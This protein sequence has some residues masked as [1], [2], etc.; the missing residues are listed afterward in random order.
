MKRNDSSAHR[1]SE[2]VPLLG[3]IRYD[4]SIEDAIG[5]ADALMKTTFAQDVK[6]LA[7]KIDK[8]S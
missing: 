3:G 5:D 2:S 6:V 4:E 7:K 8:K 1:F